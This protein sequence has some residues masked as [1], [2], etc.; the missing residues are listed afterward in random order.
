MAETERRDP[1]ELLA[2]VQREEARARRGRLHIF[3][4]ASAGVGK[5]YSMLEAART[6]R[7]GG[8]DV[9]VGYVESHGRSETERLLEGL[10]QLPRLEVRYRGI[11]RHEFDLDAALKRAPAIVLVDELAHSNLTEGEPLPRHAKRWQDVEELLDAG[12]SVWT[13]LNVQHLESLNDVVAGITGVRQQETVPDRIFDEADDVE[14]ID[15]PPDDLLARLKAGKVYISS[16]VGRATEGFFRKANLLALRELALR[17][18]A[19][20]VDAAALEFA[21]QTP[22]S[23]PWLARDRFMIAITPDDQAEPLV[24]IGKRFADALDAEWLVVSVETPQLLK[25]SESQR[26]RRIDVL[27]LAESLG[28]ETVT[29]DGATAADALLEYARLRNVTRIVIGEARRTG[30][31]ALLRR[32]TTTELVRRGRGFDIS[33]IARRDTRE[34][35]RPEMA[36]SGSPQIVRWERYWAALG[37]SACCTGIAAIMYPYFELTN[38]VMVYLLGATVAALRLGRG[39]AS[40]TAVLNVIT[41]D[42]CFVPPRFTF[43]LGNLQYLLTFAVMLALAL[44]IANLV[45]NVRAQTRVAGAR[46]RRTSLLYAMSRELAATRSFN[47]LARV[48]IRHVAE[49]FSGRAAVLLPDAQRRVHLIKDVRLPALLENADLSVAQW[50]FDHGRPAGLGTD[51][52]PAAAG[53]YLPLTATKQTLGV[54]AVEPTQRRR[55]LLPEQR[56]LLETFAG[57][58]AL[59]IE[60]AQRAEDAEAT[61]VAVETE[62]LR[63]TLLAS[64]SHDLRSPLAQIMEASRALNDQK[65][66]PEAKKRAELARAIEAKAQEISELISNVLDL[67]TFEVGVVHL[68]RDWHT[69][70]ALVGAALEGLEG[71]FDLRPIGVTLPADLPPVNVDAA[72]ITRVVVNLLENA[73]KHTPPGT[74]ISVSAELE[75]DSVRVAIDDSGP[76]LPPGDPERLFAKFQRGGTE[77]QAGG[78]GLGLSICRAIINAHGGRIYAMQR[79]EGGA[80]FAFT[81]P[82][83][84]P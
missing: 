22:T 18:T 64:I 15:L 73:F 6:A 1:D 54:L 21:V 72:L 33:V 14:L 25:A 71:R 44:V 34:P 77:P 49:T 40:C 4:G 23:R 48:A 78:A 3:F 35:D 52:L 69:I 83:A 75:G 13:T 84:A 51:T 8:A 62:S 79:P 28:A 39:P 11:V 27:R 2:D 82:T 45:A 80:R 32:S 56:H 70:D 30:L 57:Q 61:R 81:L 43:A 9:V 31:R 37:I 47:N 66:P 50:V 76:G 26:N 42:Y 38:L 55:L 16:Q 53:Q 24:R 20:R 19:D 74:G 65:S 67:M 58:I 5:T 10:P 29:I 7:A 12:I 41:L 36:R 60:R 59:A 17:R 68:K 63:S 46:E